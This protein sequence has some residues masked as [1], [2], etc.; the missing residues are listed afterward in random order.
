MTS[1][2]VTAGIA[3][4]VLLGSMSGMATAA[5]AAPS[6]GQVAAAQ[7]AAD[8][9]AAQVGRLLTAL[10]AAQTA[11][12]AA[13]SE[14]AAARGR[15]EGTLAG[16]R[17]VQDAADAALA[18]A[19]QA[20]LDLASARADV[21]A[22]ARSSYM[23]GTSSP[24]LQAL[25]TSADPTQMLERAALLEAVGS[26]RSGVLTR[27]AVVEGQAAGAAAEART[28]LAEAAALEQEAALALAAADRIANE[29]RR[30][31]ATVEAQQ[32]EMQAQLEAARIAL[33]ALQQQ[34]RTAVSGPAAPPS[35]RP[36]RPAPVAPAPTG[37]AH[38]W[39]QVAM[40]ESSGNWSINTGNG[41]YGGLQFSPSTWAEFGG[42]VYAPRAD[43]ATRS[44]QI[45]IAEK[46]LL[47]Q[48]PGAWPTCG[49]LLIAL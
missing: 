17:S 14:A 11:V 46:V 22:F 28:A 5:P 39:T 40:C 21:S 24:G 2:S 23:T 47:V 35:A 37:P 25:L 36:T 27:V 10:G 48:G 31:V 16:Y 26:R 41:Y 38:D 13:H 6:A 45:A 29:T 49:A 30:T 8:D 44:Q 42:L 19:A 7:Q 1:R 3:A 12:D 18:A 9:A 34:Q 4:A 15:H 32:V 33:V 43:L 20:Q